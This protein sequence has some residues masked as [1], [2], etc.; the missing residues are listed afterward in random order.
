VWTD[1]GRSDQ[2]NLLCI[3]EAPLPH[4]PDSAA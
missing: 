1:H 3:A 4:Q 2:I